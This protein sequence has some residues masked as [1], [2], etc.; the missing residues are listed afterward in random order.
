MV[1]K[2]GLIADVHGA[3]APLRE[4]LNIC[5]KEGVSSVLCVGDIAGYGTEIE[6]S[7]VLL[8]DHECITLLGNHEQWYLDRTAKKQENSLSTYFSSLPR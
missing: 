7:I 4:A 3:A 1:T 2:I 8:Q 6:E 5:K